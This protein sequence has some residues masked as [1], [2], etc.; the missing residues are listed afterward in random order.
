M[1]LVSIDFN[2]FIVRTFVDITGMELSFSGFHP[3]N[4]F[5]GT[6]VVGS[7]LRTAYSRT[8]HVPETKVL[9]SDAGRGSVDT[10]RCDRGPLGQEI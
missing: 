7:K 9:Q 1:Q 2:L 6:A 5:D 3:A 10:M 8:S 4:C